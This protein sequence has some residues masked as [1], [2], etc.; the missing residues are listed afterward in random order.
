[1][2]IVVVEPAV[3]LS[4]ALGLGGVAACVG[5]AIGQ[6]AVEAFDLP[7]GLGSVG[8][9]PLVFDVLHQPNPVSVTQPGYHTW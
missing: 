1:M 9:G 4:A 7:V 3:E 5:P 2:V 8:P 6:G